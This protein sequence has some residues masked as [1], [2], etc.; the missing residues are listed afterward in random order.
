MNDLFLS[1]VV[2]AAVMAFGALISMG[3]ERQR[4]AIDALHR[5]YK[6]WAVQDL[7]MKRGA[8]SAQTEIS[9]LPTWLTKVTSLAFGYKTSVMD[10]QIHIDPV[11]AIEFH[12]GTSIVVCTLEAPTMLIPRLQKKHSALQGDLRSNPLFRV[13]KKTRIVELSILNAGCM[14]D[15]ELPV[16]WSALTTQITESDTLWAYILSS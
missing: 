16:A 9:D 8:V 7:R 12:D 4:H 13:S 14:F 3:N 5:A 15:I 10:Y 11:P 6:Q 1:V 2:L